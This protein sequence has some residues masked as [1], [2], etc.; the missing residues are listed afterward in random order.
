V[1]FSESKNYFMED[2]FVNIEDGKLRYLT[3]GN[4]RPLILLHTLR[5]QAEYFQFII[6]ALAEHFKVYA[7]DLPGHGYSF[8]DNKYEYSEPYLRLCLLQFLDSLNISNAIIAGESIGGTLALTMAAHDVKA[9]IAGVIAFNPYDYGK[10]G[11]IKRSSFLASILFTMIHW[12]V[13]G[14]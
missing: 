7:L 13:F 3:A 9:R 10:G 1:I 14:G 11:G 2:H 6:P 8:N 12:P 4:G 5:T